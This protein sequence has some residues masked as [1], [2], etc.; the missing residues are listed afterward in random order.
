MGKLFANNG[1]PDQTPS[2]MGLHCL[3]VILFGAKM[4]KSACI[5]F[6]VMETKAEDGL[7]DLYDW[8]IEPAKEG[9]QSGG[10]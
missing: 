6:Q 5:S 1:D 7:A 10:M 2:D 9:I 3:P 8:L 4:G